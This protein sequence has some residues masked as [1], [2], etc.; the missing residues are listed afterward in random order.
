MRKMVVLLSLLV[1]GL[2]LAPVTQAAD[3]PVVTVTLLDPPGELLTLAVGEART[4]H[5][6]VTSSQ[7]FQLAMARSD[8][9]YPG[10]GVHWH[11]SDLVVRDTYALLALTMTGKAATADLPAVCDWPEPGLCWAEGSAPVAIAAGARFTGG[12]VTPVVFPFAVQVP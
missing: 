2:C 5:I 7:P 12:V 6:E 1:C 9:Y 11:A 8:A 10:R 4:F 3:Q